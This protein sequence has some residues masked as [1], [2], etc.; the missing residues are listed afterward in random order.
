MPGPP[1]TQGQG[2]SDTVF[3]GRDGPQF[4]ETIATVLSRGRLDFAPVTL[5]GEDFG[6]GHQICRPSAGHSASSTRTF[7]PSRNA[8]AFGTA[9]MALITASLATDDLAYI[10]R[11]DLDFVK[12]SPVRALMRPDPDGLRGIDQ[13]TGDGF[14]QFFHRPRSS[15]I[16]PQPV[17]PGSTGLTEQSP[18][19]VRRLR[20]AGNHIGG[21][22][23][24]H[25]QFHGIGQGIVVTDDLDKPAVAR[26]A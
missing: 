19:G 4:P 25:H 6:H 26:R 5:R 20:P 13:G 2:G 1:T 9:R 7:L 22:L 23:L 11:I 8:Q 15:P 17:R 10:F 3:Q 12:H 24:V 14:E 21:L 16:W 18:Y